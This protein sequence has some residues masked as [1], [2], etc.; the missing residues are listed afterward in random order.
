LPSFKP[1]DLFF[2]GVLPGSPWV[3]YGIDGGLR[4]GIPGGGCYDLPRGVTKW[5]TL[6]QAIRGAG[7]CELVA[8][9]IFYFFRG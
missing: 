2:F 3:R 5:L 6:V 8:A 9:S 7:L 1:M 4:V